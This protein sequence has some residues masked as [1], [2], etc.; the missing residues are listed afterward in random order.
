MGKV[1]F[2]PGGKSIKARAG[3]TLVS[4]AAAARVVIPQRCGGHASC[5]MCRIVL[6]NGE[7]TSPTALELRKMPEQDLA[8]GIRLG[9]QAKVTQKDCTIRIPESRFKSVV[10]AALERERSENED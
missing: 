4:T 6:E 8:K 2:L 5:L 3:Q 9:C 10:Q 7:L 1:T